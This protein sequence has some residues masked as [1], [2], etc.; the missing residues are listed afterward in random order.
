MGL[1]A[2]LHCGLWGEMMHF[3]RG[4]P[5]FLYIVVGKILTQMAWDTA[6]GTEA[7][8][9]AKPNTGY[10]LLHQ[11]FS[12]ALTARS[13]D[14][15][16]PAET[17]HDPRQFTRAGAYSWPGAEELWLDS[18]WEKTSQWAFK[19]CLSSSPLQAVIMLTYLPLGITRVLE[20]RS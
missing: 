19:T 12:T 20:R 4:P 14:T 3:S 8:T 16:P 9:A 7:T 11:D 10:S 13:W 6:P 17:M 18:V 5:F 15:A 1:F 2:R